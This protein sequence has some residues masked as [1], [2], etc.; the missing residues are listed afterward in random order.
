M[1]N[2]VNELSLIED[3]MC[4]ILAYV[5]SLNPP[6]LVETGSFVPFSR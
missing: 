3:L 2:F 6:P 4:L 5:S 1:V